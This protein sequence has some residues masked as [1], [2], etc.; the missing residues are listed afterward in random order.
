LLWDPNYKAITAAATDTIDFGWAGLNNYFDTNWYPR[1]LVPRLL[2][3]IDAAYASS[4]MKEPGL[5]FTEYNSGCES[6]IEGGVA[7]ADDLGVFGRE[8]VF[9]ATV[10]P[11][12]SLTNNYLVAAFDLYRNYD[13]LGTTVGNEAVKA[14]TSDVADTSVYAF[15]HAGNANALDLV[16]INKTAAGLKVEFQIAHAPALTSVKA[17][18]LVGAQAAVVAVKA[19]PT[20][21]CANGSCTVDYTLPATSATTL[22]LR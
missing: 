5:A 3:K 11:L 18:D 12:A 15:T 8:G 17:Y 1:Q 14:T 16:A 20:V 13:G 7:E 10:W 4:G 9:A 2:G 22:I 21:S 19:A 6:K